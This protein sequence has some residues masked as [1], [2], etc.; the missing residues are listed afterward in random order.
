MLSRVKQHSLRKDEEFARGKYL[1]KYQLGV[2]EL[3][4]IPGFKGV[5]GVPLDYMHLVLLGVVKRLIHLWLHG[6]RSEFRLSTKEVD[7][8][9]SRLVELRKS[10]PR[11]FSRRL[12]SIKSFNF[13]RATDFRTFLLYTGPIVL[14]GILKKDAYANFLLL[15]SAIQTLIDPG[16]VKLETNVINAEIC[17]QDFVRSYESLYGY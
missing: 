9:C 5:S 3:L 6:P 4:N 7:N 17:L 12:R 14:K 2:T 1:G 16:L 13:W 15:H 11:E 8:I 10:M